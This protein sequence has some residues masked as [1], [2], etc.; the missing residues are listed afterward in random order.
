MGTGVVLEICSMSASVSKPLNGHRMSESICWRERWH[1]LCLEVIVL[2]LN[3]AIGRPAW[4]FGSR[5]HM[6]DGCRY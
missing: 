1:I 3:F 6:H 4:A 5:V 2:V